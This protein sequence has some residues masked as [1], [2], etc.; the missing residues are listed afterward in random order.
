MVGIIGK[1]FG[2]AIQ[3]HLE[4]IGRTVLLKHPRE[5][6][7]DLSDCTEL[8]LAFPA[9]AYPDLFAKMREQLHWRSDWHPCLIS[10]TKGLVQGDHEVQL[11]SDFVSEQLQ[12][13][14]YHY[15]HLVGP[16]FADDLKNHRIVREVVASGSPWIIEDV[17]HLFASD[18]F[19]V[20]GSSDLAGVQATAAFRPIASAVLGA[21][22]GLITSRPELSG[23]A[24]GSIFSRLIAECRRLVIHFGGDPRSVDGQAGLADLVMCGNAEFGQYSRNWRFG[25][26]LSEGFAA[27]RALL[28]IGST[29]EAINTVEVLSQVKGFEE[30]DMPYTKALYRVIH[31]EPV[32]EQYQRIISREP[33]QEIE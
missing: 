5:D 16:A 31:G 12:G 2:S 8:V 7:Q 4:G 10:V 9:Q 29:V 15:A 25:C 6:L 28:R 18:R 24:F 22:Y 14:V 23:S 20:Y 26:F 27:D 33:G 17:R 32:M 19:G 3:A 30:L 21:A 11:P 1:S 13:H